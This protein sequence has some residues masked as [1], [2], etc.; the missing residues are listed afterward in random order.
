[1]SNTLFNAASVGA[2]NLDPRKDQF[3]Y[4]VRVS[5]VTLRINR[6][7]QERGDKTHVLYRFRWRDGEDRRQTMDSDHFNA[8]VTAAKAKATAI[9]SGNIDALVLTNSDKIAYE[10][11]VNLLKPSGI[12][13]KTAISE[14]VQARTM[15]E[16]GSL[17]EATRFFVD[18]HPKSLV[19]LTRPELVQN[20]LE[21]KARNGRSENTIHGPTSR[22][23]R[24]AETHPGPAL[25]ELAPDRIQQFVDT[26]KPVN[27]HKDRIEYPKKEVVV[28]VQGDR[29]K[30]AFNW[31][32]GKPGW[33]IQERGKRGLDRRKST[34]RRSKR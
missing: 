23:Y 12:L 3:P 10:S 9:N 22:L 17:L 7:T 34:G 14:Y 32:R 27:A 24:Y 19:S 20:C 2:S 25:E 26:V 33:L 1:M 11:S 29:I 28:M 4:I 18:R 30:A 5:N 6:Y 13:L 31:E 21:A 16:G 8:L 15:L